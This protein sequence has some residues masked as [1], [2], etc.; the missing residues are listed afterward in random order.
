ML[1]VLHTKRERMQKEMEQIRTEPSFH[2][3]SFQVTLENFGTENRLPADH[4]YGPVISS[5]FLLQYCSEGQGVL[6]ADGKCFCVKAGDC[7]ATFPGQTRIERADGRDPW[8]LSWISINGTSAGIFFDQLGLKPDR[9]LVKTK[10][11]SQILLRMQEVAACAY[12]G[13]HT[14]D[15]MLGVKLFSFMEECLRSRKEGEKSTNVT[16]ADKYVEQAVYHMNMHYFKQDLTV[17]KLADEIGLNRSYFYEIFKERTGIS[18]QKYLVWLRMQKA[19]EYLC[20]PQATVTSVAYSV[21]YE[22][23]VFSRAFKNAVGMSPGEYMR[24]CQCEENSEENITVSFDEEAI[25]KT[26]LL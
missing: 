5:G 13:G 15:F 7:I 22:P 2:K 21:G 25:V 9:L 26:G 23:S 16:D 1:G 8:V 11:H 12:Q 6:E 4:V 3:N 17:Q 24:S 20:M 18:P 10:G 14:H 19:K